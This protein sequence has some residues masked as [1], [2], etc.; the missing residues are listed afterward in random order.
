MAIS[1]DEFKQAL[2]ESVAQEFASLPQEEAIN[3]TFS[4]RFERRMNRLIRGHHPLLRRVGRPAKRVLLVAAVLLVFFGTA[5][6]PM[7]VYEPLTGFEVT[8]TEEWDNFRIPNAETD[9]IARKYH[10][11]TA[12]EGF[13]LI[14]LN[15]D[16]H[17]IMYG[18]KNELGEEITFTQHPTKNSSFSIDNEYG[19]LWNEKIG[20]RWVNFYKNKNGSFIIATWLHDGY[21]FDITYSNCAGTYTMEELIQ[22]IVPV[23]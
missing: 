19:R 4:P 3:Y 22:N 9:L 21:L 18:Y 2:R 8:H 6:S 12:P 7:P 14:L 17:Y 15:N 5:S 20:D 1:R 23:A 16:C 13:T 10:F 11:E